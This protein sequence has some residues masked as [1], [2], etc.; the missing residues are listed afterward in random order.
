MTYI[1]KHFYV[2]LGDILDSCAPK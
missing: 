2:P 1:I